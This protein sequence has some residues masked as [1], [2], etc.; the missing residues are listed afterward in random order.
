MFDF[1]LR[2]KLL[3]LLHGHEKSNKLQPCK[4]IT[5]M[6]KQK[7]SQTSTLTVSTNHTAYL[8]TQITWDYQAKVTIIIHEHGWWVLNCVPLLKSHDKRNEMH[9]FMHLFCLEL[10]CLSNLGFLERSIF[11]DGLPNLRKTSVLMSKQRITKLL[12]LASLCRIDRL[13]A[14]SWLK[15][16]SMLWRATRLQHKHWI[17]LS[18]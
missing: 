5:F 13:I 4:N 17:N 14:V 9:D 1:Y 2:H 10:L 11:V 15:Q 6:T 12:S 8:P 3:Y 7:P 18:K 16:G